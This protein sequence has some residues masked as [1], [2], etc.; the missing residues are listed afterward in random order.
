[1]NHVRI[2][3]LEKAIAE[4]PSDPFNHYALALEFQQTDPDKSAALF[5]EILTNH[6]DY[7]PVYYMAGTFYADIGQQAKAHEI[8]TKGVEL[9]KSNSDYKTMREL[10]STIQNMES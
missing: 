5:D 8:L 2:D 4:D 9:A 3:M 1:M 10:L 6:P 7:Q